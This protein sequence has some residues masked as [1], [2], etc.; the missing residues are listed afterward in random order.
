MGSSLVL[1]LFCFVFSPVFALPTMNNPDF[2]VEEIVSGLSAP[3]SMEFIDEDILV[4][5]K[6]DG[7][8][9][10]VKNNTLQEQPMLDVNVSNNSERGLLGITSLGNSIIYLY[11]TEAQSGDGS[12]PI[13]NRIYKY[14]WNGT[15][16]FDPVLVKDLPATPGP[17][18]DGGA[19]LTTAASDVY[20][21]IGD[22]NR[23]GVLQNFETG[24]LDD[25]SVIIDVNLNESILKPS[26]FANA[27]E[28][29]LAM[30]IRNSF[31]ITEDTKTGQIWITENGPNE[32]DE[33][34]LASSNFNSGWE[35]IMGP[36]TQS[37]IDSLPGFENF[38]YSDP[39]FSWE[40]PVAVTAISFVD[41]I[42]FAR[43]DDRVFVGDCNNGN[44]YYFKLNSIRTGF[45]FNNADLTD[46]VL[47]EGESDNEI[48]L[49]T[50][51]GCITDIQEHQDGV[52]YVLSL[53]MGKIFK[54]STVSGTS[55]NVPLSEDWIV[56]SS[57]T[58][59][60]NP[61]IPQNIKVQNNSVMTIPNGVT[62]DL[63]FANH[64]IIIQ[65]GSG[66]LLK[67]GGK[68]T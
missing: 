42:P 40:N 45:I 52:L 36:A 7:K 17:N 61:T 26:Q 50:G 60:S 37:E 8:V 54:V 68:I 29:Y 16:I 33:I 51:F 49:G 62:L 10:I 28:H 44:L 4:L 5:Q 19:M 1:V 3:T 35:K 2:V 13:G 57:C 25:T 66:I 32:F 20:A 6:N 47:N 21:V 34:N 9:R 14:S 30:G 38:T 18:H 56:T 12:E 65:S 22:L 23:N 55:C 27:S 15:A 48:L 67:A 11:Y 64:N 24:D 31:G 41:S 59:S 58:L 46:N 53:G 63:D 39:E 43:Y